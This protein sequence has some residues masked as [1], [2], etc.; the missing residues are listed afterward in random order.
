VSQDQ[1]HIL[2]SAHLSTGTGNSFNQPVS[3]RPVFSPPLVIELWNFCEHFVL[4][5]VMLL[6]PTYIELTRHIDLHILVSNGMAVSRSS[7]KGILERKVK[8]RLYQI[9]TKTG[10]G[11]IL[12][13]NQRQGGDLS[14]PIGVFV[15]FFW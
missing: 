3:C 4:E 5:E 2:T 12:A 6:L 15:K 13:N 9:K 11:K 8:C 1:Q 10:S 7:N 14:C